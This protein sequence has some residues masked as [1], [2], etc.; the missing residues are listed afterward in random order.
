[1]EFLQ[2][3][4]FLI[5]AIAVAV[6]LVGLLILL[7][8]RSRRISVTPR[9]LDTAVAKTTPYAQP[10]VDPIRTAIT[11]IVAGKGPLT[12]T[13]TRRLDLYRPDKLL[14]VVE[15]MN[16]E[17]AEAERGSSSQRERL[18]AIAEYV[19]SSAKQATAPLEPEAPSLKPSQPVEPEPALEP[20]PEPEPEPKPAPGAEAPEP[21]VE[22][23]AAAAET[24]P[25]VVEV[26][27]VTLEAPPVVIE[28]PPILVEA[29]VEIVEL[30]PV[31]P[32]TELNDTSTPAEEPALDAAYLMTLPSEQWEDALQHA[33]FTEL[34]EILA[35]SKD[36]GLKTKLVDHLEQDGS[37]EALILLDECLQDPDP[38]I[39]LY[40]LNAAE[41]ILR[42][43]E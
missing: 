34:R 11:T 31:P 25:E 42:D 23:P 20:E 15:S 3:S 39:R 38:E 30:E 13:E 37:P 29:P 1:M 12:A 22:V 8:V 21:A 4:Y 5:G 2:S 33:Q 18:N 28:T 10:A 27:P 19:K 14:D 36:S 24:P 26:A 41:R 6:L 40:A 17:T 7:R 35:T 16:T 9:S 32:A 43:Q